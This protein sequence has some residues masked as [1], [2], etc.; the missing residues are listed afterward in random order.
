MTS[1]DA[2]GMIMGMKLQIQS[3]NCWLN[4]RTIASNYNKYMR[5][6]EKEEHTEN[7]SRTG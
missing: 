1:L 2:Y 5:K 3:I 7:N 4:D 6:T